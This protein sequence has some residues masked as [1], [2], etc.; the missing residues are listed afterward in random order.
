MAGRLVLGRPAPGAACTWV[1]HLPPVPS[2][3]MC[4]HQ[5]E[6]RG[7]RWVVWWL[8]APGRGKL[9]DKGGENTKSTSA[10]K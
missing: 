4:R 6:D 10:K 7:R 2:S 3:H 9:A 5:P 1:L 8:R